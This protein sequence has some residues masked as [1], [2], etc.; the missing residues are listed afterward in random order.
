LL[1][2]TVLLAILSLSIIAPDLLAQSDREVVTQAAE[3]F[4]A[5]S[6]IKVHKRMAILVEGHAR[7]IQQF[8]PMQFQART[9]LDIVINKHWSVYPLGYVYTWNPLYGKQT[10]SSTTSTELSSK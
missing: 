7:F 10:N 5:S 2:K 4:S 9:G 8:E 3:W 6:T 1:Q